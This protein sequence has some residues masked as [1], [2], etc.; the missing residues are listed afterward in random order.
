[1]FILRRTM[2]TTILKKDVHPL[3]LEVCSELQTHGHQ[4]FIVGGCVR[5]L[6]LEVIPKDWDITTSAPPEE[7]MTIFPRTIPTGLQHGTITVCMGEGEAN[8]FEV[9]T[10]RVEGQYLDGR[11]PEEVKFV[12][13]IE[14]D[15]ARRDLTI[16]AI[17]YDPVA[18]RAIDPFGGIFDLRSGI[19]RAVGKPEERFQEDGLRIMRVARFAARFGY[20]VEE[21]T[22]RGMAFSRDTLKK[23][24]R[25]RVSDELCKTLM[26]QYPEYGLTILQE[27]RVLG[28]ACPLLGERILPRLHLQDRCQGELE[29]RLAMLY[30]KQPVKLVEEELLGLKMSTKEVKRVIFLLTTLE[31][32]FVFKE[33]STLSSYRKFM[34]RIK[35]EATDPWEYTY[36]QFI[37][38][39]RALELP[40]QKLT[41]YEDE[42]V[43]ARKELA[44]NGNDLMGIGITP[45]P[46]LKV[47]LEKCYSEAL[48]H[49][50]HNTREHLIQL[51]MQ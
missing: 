9:T 43:L 33:S 18:N 5:D 36:Q 6:L 49:P 24:S 51:A 21:E 45:G 4:A 22:K 17:A 30:N 38:L 37:E 2:R 47:L 40:F 11:R 7:V 35:N 41:F 27:T 26:A 46:Q 3:A 19:I 16:N 31:K 15:L 13:R 20:Q 28:I 12:K 50:E 8:H 44:I 32:F 29:A 23:V 39:A 14:E 25:E 10:F 1:M 48:E 34:A 42:V